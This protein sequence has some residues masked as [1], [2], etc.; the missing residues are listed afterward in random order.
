MVGEKGPRT[1]RLRGLEFR[2]LGFVTL[3]SSLCLRMSSFDTP[4]L[5]L[6]SSSVT[7]RTWWKVQEFRESVPWG[8][9]VWGVEG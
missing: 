5:A 1:W 2:V 6:S 8:F 4:G 9:G 3:D 7:G